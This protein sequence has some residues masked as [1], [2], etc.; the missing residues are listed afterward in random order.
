MTI[1]RVLA[2]DD[3]AGERH[4]AARDAEPNEWAHGGAIMTSH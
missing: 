2:N 3:D 1:P 4:Q